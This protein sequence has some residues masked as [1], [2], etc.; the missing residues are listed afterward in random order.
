MDKQTNTQTGILLTILRTF[1]ES[2]WL[3]RDATELNQAELKH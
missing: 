3:N 2:K 1:L